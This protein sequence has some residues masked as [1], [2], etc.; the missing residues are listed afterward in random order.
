MPSVIFWVLLTG[1]GAVELGDERALDGGDADVTSGDASEPVSDPVQVS[2]S[3]RPDGCDG[4]FTLGARATG[5]RPPYTFEWDDGSHE[6]ERR[7]C[8]AQLP[9]TLR[10]IARDAHGAVSSPH[11]TDLEL[12]D[13]ACP[14]SPPMLCLQNPSFEGK[15]AANVGL[16]PV[17]DCPGWGY[18]T[19]DDTSNTPDVVNKTIPQF[20]ASVPD[21]PDG[22]TF[23]GMTEGE[24]V[25]QVLCEPMY[26]GRVLSLQLD[27]RRIYIG[28]GVV[29]D[30]EIPYLE[31]WG[32][33][34]SDCSARELL[35]ASPPLTD[36]FTTYCAELRPSQFS[37]LL[38]L[39]ARSDETQLAVSYMFVDNL[40][41]VAACP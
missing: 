18:C 7:V 20:I 41:P 3:I 31:I 5:G 25:S 26:A 22:E 21:A 34:A 29:S 40:R 30:T 17:F 9:S 38:V 24:Q 13:A 11:V 28:A 4:C 6:R 33:V 1:C 10:V 32:G 15:P 14:P 35:W 39:R 19:E 8:P 16:S 36:V 23:M 37:N 2:V 27:L 12:P